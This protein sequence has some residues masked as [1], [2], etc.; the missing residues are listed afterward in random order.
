MKNKVKTDTNDWGVYKSR[1]IEN[2]DYRKF[3]D[4]LRMV[5]S[6]TKKQRDLL[7]DFLENEHR[8]GKLVYGLHPSD[9]AIITC[10]VFNYETEHIHFLDGSNGGYALAAQKMKKQRETD[11]TNA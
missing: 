10:V 6:G 5:L 8:M 7:T 9:S 11:Q 2:T 3:D 4:T 1:L